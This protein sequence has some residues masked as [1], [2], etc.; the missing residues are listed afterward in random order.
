MSMPIKDSTQRFSS[1][2]ENYVRYRPGYPPEILEL[3]KKECGLAR[4]SVIAEIAFGTGIFTQ[5]L[6]EDGNRVIGVE[7]NDDM[8]RAGEEFLKS[9]PRFTSVAGTAEETTLP[10]HSIDII[11]AAQ[12]A[13]WFDCGKARLEF[14][15]ILKPE[16]WLALVWNDRRLDATP[17][18][19]NYENLVITYGTDYLE[20]RH[21][22]ADRSAKAL[23][24]SS[25][26]QVRRFE[27]YQ[28]FDYP[29]LEGR[30]LSSS[31]APQSGHPNYGP[32]LV[33]LRRIYDADQIN[34]HVTFEYDTQVFYGQLE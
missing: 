11:T 1:R 20:V 12:A 22:G 21:Q 3:L 31:Y 23:F 27:M 26:F 10:D 8:R 6:L 4:D 16:A 33:E 2:V 29:A 9:Y 30:L 34:G 13:H 5:M 14:L 28:E 19:R 18:A 7:P 32:M 25:S 24:G 15:R 17:F